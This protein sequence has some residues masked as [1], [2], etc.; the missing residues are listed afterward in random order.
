MGGLKA[1]QISGYGS[2]LGWDLALPKK[3]KYILEILNLISY[4]G[5]YLYRLI[6]LFIPTWMVQCHISVEVCSKL[7]YGC[8]KHIGG[9][10]VAPS[11]PWRMFKIKGS[12]GNGNRADRAGYL[13]TRPAPFM[14]SSVGRDSSRDSRPIRRSKTNLYLLIKHGPVTSSNQTVQHRVH[15]VRKKHQS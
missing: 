10:E 6:S 8:W 14:S 1:D 9:D 12:I 11:C 13:R 3:R 7:A 4:L 5:K 15:H 2:S